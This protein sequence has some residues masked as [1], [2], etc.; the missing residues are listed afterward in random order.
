[1][2]GRCD[3]DFHMIRLL[4]VVISLEQFFFSYCL[5]CNLK[6]VASFDC[7]HLPN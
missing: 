7:F 6:S 5:S 2:S 3:Q 4:K 1:M